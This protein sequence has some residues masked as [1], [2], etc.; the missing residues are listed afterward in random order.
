MPL[1]AFGGGGPNGPTENPDLIAAGEAFDRAEAAYVTADERRREAR[2]LCD[3]LCPAM[4]S[5]LVLTREELET[6]FCGELEC[7]VEGIPVYQPDRQQR[8]ISTT[9]YLRI[10]AKDYGPRTKA[11]KA[12]RAKL[13]VA[14]PYEAAVASAKERS[15]LV[16]AMLARCCALYDLE[17]A[18]H[19]VFRAPAL[20]PAGLHLKARVFTT[21]GATLNEGGTARNDYRAAFMWGLRLADSPRAAS[22]K[23][24]SASETRRP[25]S[26]PRASARRSSTES[27]SNAWRAISASKS[28][29]PPPPPPSMTVN[30]GI[31]SSQIGTITTRWS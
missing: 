5:E 3:Q 14:E 17:D 24:M 7:D 16:P 10:E 26:S 21:F 29:R 18:A 15:G 11:G 22:M 6:W 31:G 2:A 1:P 20:T 9:R 19:A 13:K 25:Q 28:S 30:S 27:R 12:V 4:P 8:K 23:A